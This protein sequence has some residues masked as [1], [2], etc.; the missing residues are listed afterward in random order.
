MLASRTPS[1]CVDVAS[2]LR[3]VDEGDVEAARVRLLDYCQPAADPDIAHF[4]R[5]GRRG[6]G[7]GEV[8]RQFHRPAVSKEGPARERR[9][10]TPAVVDI[11]AD[12]SRQGQG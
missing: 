4:I 10:G 7:S 11:L 3:R 1:P 12:A 5:T 9:L 2:L 6:L 8:F